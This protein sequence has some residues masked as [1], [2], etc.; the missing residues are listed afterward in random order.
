MP[1]FSVVISVYNKEKFVQ[2]TIQSVLDQT[3][4][5]F[6]IVIV[7]DKSTDNSEQVITSIPSEKITYL[8][9]EKN[10]GAGAAR[11][12]GIK[13]AQGDFIALLDGDDLWDKYYLAEISA[14]IN[15]FPQHHVFATAVLKEHQHK[16]IP[17]QYSFENPK[18]E[19]FVDLNYFESSYKNT[20]LTSSSAVIHRSVFKEVGHYNETIKSGQDTDLW[21]R[22]GINY[23]VGFSTKPCATYRYA[24]QSLYKSIR[25][26][27]DRPDYL[28]YL[29]Q[30]RSNTALKKFIDLNRYS[31]IIRARLWNEPQEVATYL[32]HLDQNNLN[33]KQRFLLSLPPF[34]L[35]LAFRSQAVL[36]KLGFNV[37]AF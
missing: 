22:I 17:N 27:K 24:T 7:N 35:K 37:S 19:T 28:D 36:E 4:Q 23:R 29:N 32:D 2:E 9:L 12:I 1:K 8:P 30:E 26:V 14:L 34:A 21:I 6:E 3:I 11:N 16:T 13:A 10:V 15:I 18:G 25:S 31:L 33:R 20:L 5:D